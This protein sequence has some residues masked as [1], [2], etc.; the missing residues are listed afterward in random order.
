MNRTILLPVLSLLALSGCQWHIDLGQ[1]DTR[2]TPSRP[3]LVAPTTTDRPLAIGAR[4]LVLGDVHDAA[5][6]LV[7]TLTVTSTDPAVLEVAPASDGITPVVA[8]G[9]GTAE[10][11]VRRASGVEHGR[12]TITV[13][14]PTEHALYSMLALSS[15]ATE[16]QAEVASPRLVVGSSPRFYL[17]ALAAAA[18]LQLD[19]VLLQPDVATPGVITRVDLGTDLEVTLTTDVLGAQTVTPHA[20]GDSFHPLPTA[21]PAVPVIGVDA[22]S[23]ATLALAEPGESDATSGQCLGV[24]ALPRDASGALVEGAGADF[25]HV[26][27]GRDLGHG[28]L[29]GYHFDAAASST[30]RASENG[31]VASVTVHG[32]DFGAPVSAGSGCAVSPASR[33]PLGALAIAAAASIVARRRLR[34]TPR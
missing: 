22:T 23:V 4:V 33:S 18:V 32:S 14:A 3:R 25:R 13:L 5:D 16:A 9:A 27:A 1:P 34:R 20:S 8:L 7:E 28:D 31:A 30:V 19:G 24:V 26:E 15:G 6:Q 21:L 11:V 12:A 29:L 10:L 17:R 2:C